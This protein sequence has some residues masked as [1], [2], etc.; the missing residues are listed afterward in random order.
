MQQIKILSERGYSIRAIARVLKLSRKT[1][2]K[3]LTGSG[4]EIGEERSSNFCP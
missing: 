4:T 2:R 1:V 3:Y